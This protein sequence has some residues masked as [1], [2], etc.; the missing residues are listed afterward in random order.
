MLPSFLAASVALLAIGAQAI[1]QQGGGGSGYGSGGQSQAASSTYSYAASSTVKAAAATVSQAAVSTSTV[2]CNNSPDLCNRNYNNITHMGAHDAAFL[3]NAATDYTVS[4]NQFYNATVALSAGIRLI[5]AQVH[6]LNGTLELCHTTCSL[7]DG[8]SLE[9]FLTEIKTWMDNNANEVV[10]LLLVNSDDL[11]ASEFGSVFSS[12][13]ISK[14][15]YTPSSTSAMSTWP[16]LQTLIDADTR[17]ITFIASITYSSTYPYLLPEFT[18]VFE[19]AY[20]VS[21]LSGFNCTLDRP[22]TVSSA[23]SGISSGYMGLINHFADTAEALGI[24][25]PDVNDIATTNSPET[26]VTGSLGT[27]GALCDSEWGEKPTF[28]LVDFWNV[29]PAI[30][31]ADNLNGITAT[32]RTSVSTNVLSSSSS[33]SKAAAGLYLNGRTVAAVA[34]AVVALGNF[35][36]L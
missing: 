5:Q 25:I 8:G 23:T 7:L 20:G 22:S 29:G 27:H 12:S 18:Y 9:T 10:T 1:P 3:R 30:T 13:G 36:W 26:N 35:V 19:T 31:A 32:G 16:T 4:G 6:N 15:G 28:I 2:A 14:Y 34:L 24:T 17:L 21:S 33:S 11:D